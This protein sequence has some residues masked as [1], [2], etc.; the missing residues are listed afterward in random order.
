[1]APGD[2]MI[3]EMKWQLQPPFGAVIVHNYVSYGGRVDFFPNFCDFGESFCRL[4]RR[5]GGR[6]QVSVAGG[7]LWTGM[8]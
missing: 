4:G 6:V 1:V 3:S 2:T 8:S 7:S 5:L